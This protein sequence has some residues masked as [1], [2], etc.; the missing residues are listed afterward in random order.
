MD[1]HALNEARNYVSASGFL[2]LG[3]NAVLYLIFI[4]SSWLTGVPFAEL[5]AGMSDTLPFIMGI[6][7]LVAATAMIIL[8][9]RDMFAIFFVMMS[10]WQ[11]FMA[12]SK[13][14]MW[15]I[16]IFAF[17]LLMALIILTSKDKRKWFL[18]LF[19]M[20]LF[21][22]GVLVMCGLINL[23]VYGIICG[24][25]ALI[26]LYLAFCCASGKFNLPDS[27]LFKGDEKSTFKTSG[28]ALGYLLFTFITAGYVAY[29]IFG[30][31]ILPLENLIT[32]KLLCGV[33][34]MYVAVMLFAVAKMRFTPVMFFLI[35]VACLAT[36]YSTGLMFIGIA[37]FY[38]V[39]GLVAILRK[40]SRILPGIML[41]VYGCSCFFSAHAGIN[42]PAASLVLNAVPCAIAIYLAFAVYSQ[43]K[44]PL[45]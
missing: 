17:L 41:I 14:N 8:Q 33:L 24:I 4:M 23:A 32:M 37:V 1:E 40:D 21:I 25:L 38:I 7:L 6:A 31:E 30:N 44:L 27:S 28:S 15:D 12:F 10:F 13:V 43:K 18:F 39:L 36:I 35:G 26:A 34:M 5:F 29:Y 16:V 11:L 9:K 20:I 2:L 19:P 22:S 3:I 42:A 45:F